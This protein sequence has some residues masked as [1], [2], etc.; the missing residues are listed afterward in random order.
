MGWN[1]SPGGATE[2]SPALQRVRENSLSRNQ[3][4]WIGRKPSPG[5]ATELSPALQ[6][7]ERWGNDSSPGGTT[8]FRRH[9]QGLVSR[10]DNLGDRLAALFR[11]KQSHQRGLHYLSHRIARKRIEHEQ[12]RRQ[13]VDCQQL[14][15]PR[16]KRRQIECIVLYI[17]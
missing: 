15:R 10:A 17:V 4:E 5:G 6:R 8:E 1:P 9:S 12:P 16:T 11:S 2:L 7:W 13:F 14:P 3:V